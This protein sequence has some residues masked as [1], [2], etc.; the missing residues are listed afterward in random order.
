MI[1]L[2]MHKPQ[3]QATLAKYTKIPEIFFQF[4]FRI[5]DWDRGGGG[6]NLRKLEGGEHFEFSGVPEFDPFLK[7]FFRKSSIWEPKVQAFPRTSNFRRE[8]PPLEFGTFWPPLS[9]S[10]I[11]IQQRKSKILVYTYIYAVELKA[12]PSFAFL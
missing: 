4:R 10:P 3:Q 9:R 2:G 11:V 1:M 7:R 12:G 8:F 5:G 6:S